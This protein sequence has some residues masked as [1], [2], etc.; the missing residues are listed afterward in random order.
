M[1]TPQGSK[2]YQ[3]V[4]LRAN[5]GEKEEKE[6]EEEKEEEEKEEEEEE[7]EVQGERVPQALP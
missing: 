4:Q 6:A 1:S 2:A 5:R 3:T 7:E